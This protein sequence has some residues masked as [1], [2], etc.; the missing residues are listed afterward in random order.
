MPANSSANGGA[1]SEPARA[2]PRFRGRNGGGV[3]AGERLENG[4]GPT[5]VLYLSFWPE[6]SK[7]VGR[8]QHIF[9]PPTR[10]FLPRCRKNVYRTFPPHPAVAVPGGRGDDSGP[11]KWYCRDFVFDPRQVF[12]RCSRFQRSFSSASSNCLT[13]ANVSCRLLRAIAWPHTEVTPS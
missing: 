9:P 8:G 2:R 12:N 6:N 1:E 10:G 5:S 13:D 3:Y 7:N 11:S 4:D